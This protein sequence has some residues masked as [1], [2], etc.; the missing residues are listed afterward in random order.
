MRVKEVI[1]TQLVPDRRI[2]RVGGGELAH[3]GGR[4]SRLHWQIVLR[5]V[6]RAVSAPQHHDVG[7][8][9]LAKPPQAGA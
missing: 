6:S 3:R 2:N 7:E 4:R 8:D 1:I 9:W 5:V